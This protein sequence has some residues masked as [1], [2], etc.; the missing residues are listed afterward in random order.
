MR[1]PSPP[2]KA[3]ERPRKEEKRKEPPTSKVTEV[4][5]ERKRQADTENVAPRPT[6]EKKCT[7][8]AAPA[9]DEKDLLKNYPKKVSFWVDLN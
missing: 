1:K 9:K 8:S 3:L 4:R 5:T 6:K 2:S 7:E